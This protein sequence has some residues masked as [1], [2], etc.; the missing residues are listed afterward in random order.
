[1]STAICPR[2]SVAGL[3]KVEDAEPT[4]SDRYHDESGDIELLSSD[5]VLFKLHAYNLQASSYVNFT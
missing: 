2:F 3:V 5:N 4:R 1:M